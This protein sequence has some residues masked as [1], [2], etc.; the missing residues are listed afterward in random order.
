VKNALVHD[1][2]INR[3]ATI[4]NALVAESIVGES[5]WVKGGFKKLNV[6]DSSLVEI[7]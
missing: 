7:P 6:S 5:S 1:S 2:I 4:E 3:E